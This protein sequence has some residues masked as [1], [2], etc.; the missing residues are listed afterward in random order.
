MNCND[1]ADARKAVGTTQVPWR[2]ATVRGEPYEVAGY[3]LAPIARIW[4]YAAGQGTLRARSILGRGGGMVYVRPVAVEVEQD[5][6]AQRIKLSRP[7]RWILVSMLSAGASITVL[8][9]A[10]RQ[11]IRRDRRLSCVSEAAVPATP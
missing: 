5:G 4:T 9:W 6:R 7:T 10:V 11:R 1:Q 8:L 2:M 3:R